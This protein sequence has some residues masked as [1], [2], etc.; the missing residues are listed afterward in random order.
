MGTVALPEMKRYR[1]DPALAT[2]CVAAGGTLGILIPPSVGFIIYGIITEQSIGK[3]FIAGIIPGITQASIYIM[4]IYILCRLNPD[5]GPPGPSTTLKQKLMSINKTWAVLLLFILVIGGLY[6]GVFSPTEAAGIG[7][8]GAFAFALIRRKLH[9]HAFKESVVE[10]VKTTGMIFIIIT[11]AMILGYFL[12]VSRVPSEL[13]GYINAL[14]V[15]RYVILG[16]IILFYM[17]LGCIMDGIAMVLITVPIFFPLILALG[18]DGIWFGVIVTV[19]AEIGLITPPVGLNVF[20]IQGIA[21]DV[22]MYTIFRGILP[23]FVADL[24]LV[25]FLVAFPQISL[26]LPGMMT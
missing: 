13:A 17:F 9:W 15:S 8:F 4:T 26:F 6:F 19:M 10:T 3:L 14:P 16:I 21:K 12:A 11:G 22:P 24:I 18:F 1:Y 7:A 2:G 25:V 23:F 20:V 5:M